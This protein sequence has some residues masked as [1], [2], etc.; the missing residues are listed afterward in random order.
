MSFASSDNSFWQFLHH[1]DAIGQALFI[2]LLL[3]SVISW[4]NIVLHAVACC[5]KNKFS[6]QFQQKFTQSGSLTELKKIAESAAENNP[7]AI[8]TLTSLHTRQRYLALGVAD[9]RAQGSQQDFIASQMQKNIDAQISMAEKGLTLFATIAATAP[10]IGLFGTVWG[11]YHALTA[12]GQ[13]ASASLENVAG[14]VGEALIMTGIGLSVAVPAV[15][16]YNLLMRQHRLFSASLN[17][18]ACDLLPCLLSESLL[19]A[20]PHEAVTPATERTVC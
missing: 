19:Y 9:Q 17:H 1:S 15:V 6:A 16:A 2:L 18:F 5:K 7:L 4:V 14:P 8:L 13:Q 3:M 10:F 20:L 12:I 11:V